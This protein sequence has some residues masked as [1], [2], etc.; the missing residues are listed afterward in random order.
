MMDSSEH[1]NESLLSMKGREFFDQLSD[2][3]HSMAFDVGA[4]TCSDVTV[5]CME[6][7]LNSSDE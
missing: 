7:A 6:R 1:R 2:Y 5:I 4:H 3:K